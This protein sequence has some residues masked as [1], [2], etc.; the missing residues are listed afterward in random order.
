MGILKCYPIPPHLIWS[1]WQSNADCT[2][3]Q[4]NL[5]RPWSQQFIYHHRRVQRLPC[6]FHQHID[7]ATRGINSLEH[8]YMAFRN[9]YREEPLPAFGK[10]NHAAILLRSKYVN[11]LWH[12]TPVMREIRK[13][14]GQS[15]M[16]YSLHYLMQSGARSRTPLSTSLM[17]SMDSLWESVVDLICKTTEAAVPETAVKSFHNLKHQPGCQKHIH[18]SLRLRDLLV[19]GQQPP[20]ERQQ[21]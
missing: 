10:S 17:I 14:S 16:P 12:M 9:G 21:D 11:K 20:S 15:R 4:G 19:L 18:C 2:F 3:Y 13:W 1:Y 5:H 8:C 6:P 7:C